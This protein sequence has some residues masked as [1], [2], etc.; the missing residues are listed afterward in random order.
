MWENLQTIV[1]MFPEAVIAGAVISA[2]C[3]MLG[4]FVILKRVVFIGIALSE[5]AACGIA[6]AI[7]CHIHP[8]LGAAA[9]TLATVTVLSYPFEGN[10]LPRDAVLGI[11]FVLASAASILL[12]ANSGFGLQDVKALLYGDL[13]LTSDADLTLILWIFIPIGIYLLAFGRPTLYTFLDREA[14]RV[15]GLRVVLWELLYFFSLG[16]AVS[17]ASKVAGALLVFC[18]LV[19]APSTALLL[20]RK[21]WLVMV[22]S[23]TAAVAAT[24]GG[25]YV[26][27]SR[28]L[29]TNQ[30]IAATAC[31][32]L[33][34][35]VVVSVVRR[36]M[37]LTL[38]VVEK[39]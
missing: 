23:V 18:Y 4:V 8:F 17:A 15:L 34:A 20:S 22:I 28:D 29:P 30:T 9:L 5:V 13:I 10:R 38:H 31:V 33:G 14:A 12:V 36:I 27:F 26:S 7:M 21:L 37:S 6:A 35:A 2:V 3:A 11:I 19:V 25:L 39:L 16:L 1:E 24:M 32:V